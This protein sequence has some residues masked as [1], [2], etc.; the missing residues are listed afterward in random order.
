MFAEILRGKNGIESRSAVLQTDRL[1]LFRGKDF[2]RWCR[3]NPEAVPN[4]VSRKG[5]CV[6]PRNCV[7][8][9]GG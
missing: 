1:D 2:A 9:G 3:D 6:N 8:Y 5:M 4:V 7:V